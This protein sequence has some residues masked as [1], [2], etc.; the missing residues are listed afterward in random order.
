MRQGSQ[1]CRIQNSGYGNRVEGSRG[2]CLTGEELRTII[3]SLCSSG[4]TGKLSDKG[5]C[6]RDRKECVPAVG[7]YHSYGKDDFSVRLGG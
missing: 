1:G 7:P 6:D 5:D 4:K 3:G 2:F